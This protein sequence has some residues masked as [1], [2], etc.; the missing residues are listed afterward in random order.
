MMFIDVCIP[1]NNE[2]KFIEVASRIGTKGL[3]FLYDKQEKNLSE[4]QKST[5]IKLYSG[6]LV[7]NNTNNPGITFAKGEQ[8]NIENRNLKFMYDFEEQEQKDSF[9]Y[10][11]SGA[12]QV[13]C[14]IMK[15]KEKVMVFDMEKILL[16]SKM[17]ELL[18]GRMIQNLMLAKK[19]KLETII[20]SFAT[21]PE[22]LRTE[23]EY[24]S[25][26]RAFGY[27]DLAK[28]ATNN[29]HIILEQ[30]E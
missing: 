21:K 12:N 4:L 20:C 13:L 15:E 7:K 11:R 19:Y 9:H 29:L 26:I 5:K 10:R 23:M 27:E 25:L 2:E 16:A 18:L 28:Q 17:R 14:N 1:N 3:L 22:N 6:I 30:K 8:Q 24:A